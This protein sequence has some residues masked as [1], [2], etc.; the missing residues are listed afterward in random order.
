MTTRSL[1][2]EQALIGLILVSPSALANLDLSPGDFLDESHREIYET[3]LSMSAA[4]HVINVVTVSA[5]LD[6]LTGQNWLP[7][8]G[9][10]AKNTVV[11]DGSANEYARVAR[12]ESRIRTA[13]GVAENMVFALRETKDLTA[14]D[15]AIRELMAIGQNARN[16]DYTAKDM[17]RGAVDKLEAAFDAH[18]NGK[19]MGIPTGLADLDKSL[20]GFHKTDLIAVPARPAMGK[21]ALM[22]NF[23]LGSESRCGIISSEQGHDQLG[24]R[25]IS[26]DGSVSSHNMRIGDLEESDWNKITASSARLINKN[27]WVNDKSNITIEEIQRK[28]REWVYK[29]EIEILFVDYIQRIKTTKQFPTKAAQVEEVTVGLKN[30]AKELDIPVVALAQVNRDCEKRQNK[31]PH[32]GD[33]ADASI[34]EKESDGIIILYRDEVYNEDSPHKGLAEFDVAKNRHGPTGVIRAVWKADYLQFKNMMRA[35]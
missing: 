10:L 20:G 2:A 8:L 9:D 11:T 30:I 29:Y 31:R 25:C 6:R 5:E 28:A 12:E 3:V 26:I 34:I 1:M 14:V 22:L 32:M 13:V 19:P 27:I 17:V 7:V 16:Y 18:C 33:I 23:A 35:V 21:T 4:G 24:L 15:S